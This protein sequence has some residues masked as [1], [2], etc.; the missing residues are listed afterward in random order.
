MDNEKKNTAAAHTG[1][2]TVLCGKNVEVLNI[3][4]GSAKS[5]PPGLKGLQ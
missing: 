3:R 1:Y 5:N 4:F 2:S